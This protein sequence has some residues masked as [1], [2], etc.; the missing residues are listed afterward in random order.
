M[1]ANLIA[2]LRD[3]AVSTSSPGPD[4]VI[5]CGTVLGEI[6]GSQPGHDVETAVS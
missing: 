1:T 6:P 5:C 2:A 4:P 3:A